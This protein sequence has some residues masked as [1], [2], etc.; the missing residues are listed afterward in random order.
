[1]PG[2]LSISRQPRLQPSSWGVQDLEVETPLCDD[3]SKYPADDQQIVFP[4]IFISHSFYSLFY[5]VLDRGFQKEKLPT[6]G[7][8]V[9]GWVK[10]N[11]SKKVILCKF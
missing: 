3:G 4:L 8:N 11:F 9:G 7:Q 10:T 6:P 2:L 1:M 5:I